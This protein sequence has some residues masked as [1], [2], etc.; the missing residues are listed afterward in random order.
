MLAA[1]ERRAGPWAALDLA[2]SVATGRPWLDHHRGSDPD[3][4]S[5]V[6]LSCELIGGEL[7]TDEQLGD[8][9]AE[10]ARR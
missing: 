10:A 7:Q 1:Q 9:L 3:G 2:V 5:T 8:R 4:A 6:V